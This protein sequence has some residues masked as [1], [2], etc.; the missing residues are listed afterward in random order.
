[1]GVK[2]ESEDPN[3]VFQITAYATNMAENPTADASV[4]TVFRP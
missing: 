2:P 1:M 3:P 4:D